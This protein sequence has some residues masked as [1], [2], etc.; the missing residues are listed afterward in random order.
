MQ[1]KPAYLAAALLELLRF[2][3]LAALPAA[4]GLYGPGGLHSFARGALSAQLLFPVAFFFLWRDGARYAPY[5][6][7]ALLGKVLDLAF[8]LPV[9]VDLF[10]ALGGRNPETPPSPGLGLGLLAA[11]A[12][13]D[14]AGI[15]I[16][17][18]ARPASFGPDQADAAVEPAPG[19][20]GESDI[21]RVEV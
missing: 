15:L 21:E 9:G 4:Y 16:L 8:L 2:P 10:L 1:R 3:A 7:L 14:L 18:L 20:G 11:V 19:P 5:R 6:P 12:A 17:A 13:I